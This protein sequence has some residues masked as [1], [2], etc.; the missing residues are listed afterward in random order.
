[1]LRNLLLKLIASLLA[2]VPDD[3][4]I[5]ELSTEL[6]DKITPLP[7]FDTETLWV[8]NAEGLRSIFAIARS[9]PDDNIALLTVQANSEWTISNDD[10][11]EWPQDGPGPE[12]M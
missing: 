3:T 5:E 7:I 12:D 1:M 6:A 9:E 2:K 11:E 8:L 10:V 4:P